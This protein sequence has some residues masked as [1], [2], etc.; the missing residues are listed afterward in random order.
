MRHWFSSTQRQVAFILAASL[1]L[2]QALVVLTVVV[3]F[4][5]GEPLVP[6]ATAVALQMI[7]GLY[8]RLPAERTLILHMAAE[9]GVSV[10]PADAALLQ[11]CGV[12]NRA[13]AGERRPISCHEEPGDPERASVIVPAGDTWLA[14]SSFAIHYEAPPHPRHPWVQFYALVLGIALPTLVLSLWGS[15]RVTAPLKQL[16]AAAE[17]IEPDGPTASLPVSGTA[18]IRLLAD[19]FNRLIERLQAFASG[20]R[21]MVAAVS[22]DLRTPLTRLR[23]RVDAV[24]DAALREKLIRDLDTMQIITD[25]SLSLVRAQ[26]N[27][28]S[29]VSVDLGALLQTIGDGFSDTGADVSVA[30][31]CHLNAA[32]DPAMLTRAIENLVENAVKFAGSVLV[33]LNRDDRAALIDIEDHGPGVPDADKAR[34][35]EPYYRGDAA[36]TGV[37]GTGL[38]L[39]IANAIAAAHGG[40]L[41]LCD[42]YP[43]GLRV[44][45]TL[46]LAA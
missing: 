1:V 30:G 15:R 41:T 32:C 4:R 46:P 33:T 19:S 7:G 40:T 31:L 3:M 9:A 20:Q 17:A 23:L 11:R 45:M 36:R 42:A 28:V 21:R 5:E 27:G 14:A 8:E 37:D 38:G 43:T 24:E 44:R 10:A 35:L 26:E 6:P 22:H 18:E 2:S 39:S 34:V 25:G 29:A 16:A 12:A 13:P